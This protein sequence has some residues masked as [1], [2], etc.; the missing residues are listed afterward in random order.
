MGDACGP[1]LCHNPILGCDI[2]YCDRRLALLEDAASADREVTAL[3]RPLD[4][5]VT[6]M[7]FG[8]YPSGAV[9]LLEDSVMVV[10]CLSY[11]NTSHN[12]TPRNPIHSTP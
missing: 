10:G 6:L 8:L 7:P 2:K 3:A 9:E 5:S 4:I 1:V 12:V 11:P